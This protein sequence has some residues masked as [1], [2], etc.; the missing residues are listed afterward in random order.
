MSKQR[1]VL[2]IASV[3]GIVA[4]FLPWVSI[5]ILGVT[6]TVS[7]IEGDGMITLIL[8]IIVGVICVLGN[9]AEPLGKIKFLCALLGAGCAVVALFA[10]VEIGGILTLLTGIG[11]CILSFLRMERKETV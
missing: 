10:P 4:A 2:I 7:G 11:V 8:F 9:R 1:M 5:T 3:I 6:A